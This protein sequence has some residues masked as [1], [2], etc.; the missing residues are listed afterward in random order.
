MAVLSHIF[1]APT[2]GY[3]E[4][5]EKA[6]THCGDGSICTVPKRV[7]VSISRA[8]EIIGF[9]WSP[10]D[11]PTFGQDRIYPFDDPLLLRKRGERNAELRYVLV[12]EVVDVRPF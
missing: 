4:K 2:R 7:P 3:F 12:L 8:I 9:S 11:F 6:K 5:S 1:R 10:T